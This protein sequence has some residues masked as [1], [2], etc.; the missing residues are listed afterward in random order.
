MEDVQCLE[1]KEWEEERNKGS[2]DKK[3]QPI[4]AVLTSDAGL[5]FYTSMPK[6]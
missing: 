3:N 5:F 4:Y 2:K 6:C 1:W